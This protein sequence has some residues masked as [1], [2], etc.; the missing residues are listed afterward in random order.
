MF[1]TVLIAD[2]SAAT[3]KPVKESKD[4]IWLGVARAGLAVE[5]VY[6]RTRLEAEAWLDMFFASERSAG[7][8]V[9]AGF[10]FPFGYPKG[11][12]RQL[13]GQDDPFAVWQWVSQRIT[14]DEKGQN[15]RFAVAS[16]INRAFPGAGPLWGSRAKT[17]GQKF[18]IA[19]PGSSM[20]SWQSGA[21]RI[22]LPRPRLPV[23]SCSSTR[24]LEAS[25]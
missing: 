10:D 3:R 1:D 12:A 5:Q 20:T 7:R 22:S 18:P 21:K 13:T 24:R 6:C 25:S 17:P 15:N 11:F 8:K 9:L 23:F 14:D 16:E 2:W 19:S 4:A